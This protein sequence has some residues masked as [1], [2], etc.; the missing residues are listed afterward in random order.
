MTEGRGLEERFALSWR[1]RV[2]LRFQISDLRY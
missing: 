1:Q 2:D